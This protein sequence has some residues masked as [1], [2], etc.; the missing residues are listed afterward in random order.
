MDTIFRD[1]LSTFQEAIDIAI[2]RVSAVAEVYAEPHL[3][4]RTPARNENAQWL[5]GALGDLKERS[6][7]PGFRIDGERWMCIDWPQWHADLAH[8]LVTPPHY[9]WRE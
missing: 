4:A 9:Y 8:R 7:I 3:M 1:E 2:A 5:L 6:H